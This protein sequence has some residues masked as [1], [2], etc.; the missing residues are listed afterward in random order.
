EQRAI[1]RRINPTPDNAHDYRREHLREKEQCPVQHPA[2]Q[3]S[4]TGDEYCHQQTQ[5]HWNDQCCHDPDQ[6][7]LNAVK[8]EWILQ[9]VSIILQSNELPVRETL[10]V[11]EAQLNQLNQRTE[12]KDTVQKDC[13]QQKR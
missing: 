6:I 5:H 7:V 10:P 8:E 1:V 13:R 11:R 4:G 12:E 9:R 2:P 3:V